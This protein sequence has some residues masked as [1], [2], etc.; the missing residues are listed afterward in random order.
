MTLKGLR[1]GGNNAK[2]R[3]RSGT[4]KEKEAEREAEK[5]SCQGSF[6][7]ASRNFQKRGCERDAKKEGKG[8]CKGS[9]S[10]D[11]QRDGRTN[12]S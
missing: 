3:K 10:G 4:G 1:K 6:D 7:F 9:F 2:T 8:T 11:T 5:T 12:Y